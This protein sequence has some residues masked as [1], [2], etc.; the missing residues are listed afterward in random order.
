MA[1]K[2]G[3]KAKPKVVPIK[4][5][6]YAHIHKLMV[7]VALLAFVVVIASGLSSGASIF[8]ISWRALVVML[9]VKLIS[10]VVLRI[11]TTYEE[12]N[13]SGKA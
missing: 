3:A 5:V 7:G 12:M 9:L 2:K 4:K 11:I 1:A 6:N 8:S 10:V 13:N